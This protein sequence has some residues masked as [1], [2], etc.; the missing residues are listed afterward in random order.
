MIFLLHPQ[1]VIDGATGAS[2]QSDI[3]VD[4]ISFSTISKPCP[5]EGN[6]TPSELYSG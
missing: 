6:V 2:W 4:D 5:G 1:V 3:A